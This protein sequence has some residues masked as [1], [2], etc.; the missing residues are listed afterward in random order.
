MA[1]QKRPP[2]RA[3]ARLDRSE[4][5]RIHRGLERGESARSIA[6]DLGRSPSTVCSEV[7]R[8]RY[9][10]SP[11]EHR[12][13][14]APSDE[15]LAQ[16]CPGLAKWPR[17]CNGCAK[18]RGYGC[19]RRPRVYYD[20]RAAQLQADAE[21]SLSRRGIDADEEEAARQIA[22]IRDGLARGLSPEQ[23]VASGAVTVSVSTVY[24]WA[25]RGYAGMSNMDLRRKVGYRKRRRSAP[26][27][28]TS[29]SPRR[30]HAAFLA[31][32]DECAG[33]WEMDTVE[34]RR[35]DRACLLTLLHRPSR[36][37]LLLPMP[38]KEA[39]G[40]EAWLRRL[41]SALGPGAARRV[42]AL[43]LTDNGAE[44]SDER[45]L[46]AAIGERPGET[47]LFYCDPGRADQKGGCEKNHVEVRK[48]FP[49]GRG[50]VSLEGVGEADCTAAMSHVN[51]S[52]RP[53][54]GGLCPAAAFRAMLGAD[55]DALLD[56]LGVEQL[57]YAEVLMSPEA[58]NRARR[59]RGEAPLA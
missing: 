4:R 7:Q 3:Y 32:G 37:Q 57:P 42:F 17:C 6:A 8:H 30:S 29:H 41:S 45:A 46:A 14:P 53:S 44:F 15:A 9:V 13:Q 10:T 49:K 58:V 1:R 16:S 18:R 40:P 50:G 19:S 56:A 23:M 51:S 39:G 26:E 24:R 31:L 2:D 36:L 48:V 38:S 12:G 55:A 20:P 21:L 54:L 47:R 34:G 28:A 11:R 43:V 27:R 25:E 22:A 33:A 35:G 5:N 59:E 52:P